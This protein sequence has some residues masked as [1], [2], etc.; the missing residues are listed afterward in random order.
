LHDRGEDGSEVQGLRQEIT[1]LRQMMSEGLSNR[2]TEKITRLEDE[3]KEKDRK[4]QEE[5]EQ[6]H[7][8]ELKALE[9]RMDSRIEALKSAEGTVFERQSVK[10]A[11]RIG[12]V[13]ER[14]VTLGEK[15]VVSTAFKH[16]IL[17]SESPPMRE[18]EGPGGIEDL[19][20][21]EYLERQVKEAADA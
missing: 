21:E 20:P 13:G 1:S 12:D 6:R 14:L 3:I 8:N 7:R 15:L 9:E 2:E 10:A 4:L 5:K 16:G 11:E 17:E 18:R 19:I